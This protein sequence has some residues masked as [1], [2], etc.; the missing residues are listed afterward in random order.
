VGEQL[1]PRESLM[2]RMRKNFS[3]IATIALFGL[4]AGCG[5]DMSD[6]AELDR[7][8]DLA[9]ADDSLA[10]L[11]DAALQ[12]AEPEQ[13]EP[14][15]QQP[16]TQQPRTQQPA[17]AQPRPR[18]EPEPVDPGPQFENLT[19]AGGTSVLVSLDQELSTKTSQVGDLFTTTLTAAVVVGNR[20]AI[21]AGARI[22]GH[23]TAVQKSGGS[24]EAAVLKLAFDEVTVD[25]DT[26]PVSMSVAEANPTM[27]GRDGTAEKVGKIGV[28][29]AAGAILGRVI[30]GNKTGTIVGG[31]IGAAAGTAIVLGSEDSDAILAE[32]SAMTLTLDAP[33]TIRREV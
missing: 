23:V 10:Q 25:G 11:E 7:E 21:P 17:A 30:G 5:G 31:A 19:V 6:Q 9:M 29:A 24:G 28:G 2:M 15:A 3:T 12:D 26:Y 1:Y 13:P 4:A 33:L 18:P 27:E 14:V 32:G 8:M 20:V 22:R 16:R